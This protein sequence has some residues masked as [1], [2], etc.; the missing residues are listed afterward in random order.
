MEKKTSIEA[1]KHEQLLNRINK[2]YSDYCDSM[3][4]LDKSEIISNAHEIAATNNAFKHMSNIRNLSICEM[5]F[6]LK[7]VNPL[8][9]VANHL[10]SVHG[11]NEI[12]LILDNC[13]EEI[14]DT[15]DALVDYPLMDDS[16]E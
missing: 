9:I 12:E 5:D 14:C 15:Q 6:L 1:Q 8:E 3:I 10:P 13:I 4:K 11:E 7:F 16:E 2:N